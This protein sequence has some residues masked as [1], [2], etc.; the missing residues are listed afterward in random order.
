MAPSNVALLLALALF[1]PTA[2]PAYHAVERPLPS[3][4]YNDGDLLTGNLNVAI[5]WYGNVTKVQKNKI[6]AFIK[7]I[8]A[9]RP[10][11]PNVN[12]WWKVVES[13]QTFAG[14]PAGPIRVKLVN[15][16]SDPGYSKGKVL[17][18][19]MIMALI[20][21][22]TGGNNNILPIIVASDGVTL[23]NM[24]AGSCWQH[25]SLTINDKPQ[26]YVLVGNPENECPICAWPFVR[27]VHAPAGSPVLRPPSSNVAADA[28]VMSLAGGLMG[29]VTNPHGE[30]F[31]TEFRNDE[32]DATASCK[33]AF[34]SG[35]SRG[36][37]GKVM[38]DRRT[39]G[40]YNVHGVARQR[41]L[42]PGVWNPKTKSCWTP[43]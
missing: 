4:T 24:C 8:N 39:F 3:L 19:D 25:G 17:I 30:G 41:F 18:K 21:S 1:L 35:Y 16:K 15:Q 29:A 33:G 34:G 11:Q 38:I 20:P 5:M 26:A 42:I 6:I 7:S 31:Y 9:V 37:P 32:V 36:N 23:Q 10:T 27:D 28:M 40:S 14:K 22:L 12:N 43:L 13:Y 2:T